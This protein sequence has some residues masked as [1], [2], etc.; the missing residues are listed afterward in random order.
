[1]EWDP[2]RYA[3]YA[4]ERGRPFVDLVAQIGAL[5]P[6]RVVDAGCGSGE[7]TALLAQRWPAA[8]VHG[9]DSSPEM[10]ARARASAGDRL[11]FGGGDVREWSPG[12]DVDVLTSNAVLQ[13]VPDHLSL[14]ARWADALPAGAWMAWQVPGNFGSPSHV[15]MRE[16]ADSP[17]WRARLAGV[18]RHD[19][20]HEPAEY[21]ALLRG[22]GWLVSA[23]ETTYLHVLPGDD[24]VLDWVRGTGLRPVLAAL[25]DADAAAFSAEYAG[26]L[27][28]AYPATPHG[29]PFPFRR[30]F[31]VGYKPSEATS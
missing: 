20:V 14:L 30:I 11:S 3:Q 24:P 5:A 15:L 17:R 8:E 18:L 28:T 12:T 7:L 6:R 27:R 19:A 25:T 29:T 10:I 31:C 26:Q 2:Q 9:F 16:L 4:N 23:W 1:M 13:W 22:R 21:D